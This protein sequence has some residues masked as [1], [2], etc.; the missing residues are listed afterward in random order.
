MW[1]PQTFPFEG[2]TLWSKCKQ[3]F[4]FAGARA[5]G[6][7]TGEPKCTS[8]YYVDAEGAH[9]SHCQQKNTVGCRCPLSMTFI[10]PP[11]CLNALAACVCGGVTWLAGNSSFEIPWEEVGGLVEA[12]TI[13]AD[14][15]VFSDQ[16]P[17]PFDEWVPWSKASSCFGSG[18]E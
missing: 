8:L 15:L 11:V 17:Y 5:G 3:C 14:T 4:G 10:H 1:A 18:D 6:G 2:W 7:G 13:K 12:G 16:S 9:P